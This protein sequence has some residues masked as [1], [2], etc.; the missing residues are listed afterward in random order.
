MP[1]PAGDGRPCALLGGRLY[2]RD[3]SHMTE[4]DKTIDDDVPIGAITQISEMAINAVLKDIRPFIYWKK[5][6][7]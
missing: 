2:F 1:C 7:R 5:T 3:R 6:G 4:H